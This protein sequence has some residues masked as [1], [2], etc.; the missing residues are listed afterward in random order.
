MKEEK[1]EKYLTIV[2]EEEEV[3]EKTLRTS[4]KAMETGLEES[5]MIAS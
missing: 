4:L 3:L 5:P 1:F 2:S